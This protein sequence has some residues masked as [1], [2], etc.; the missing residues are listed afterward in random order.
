M[1]VK[2]LIAL[3]RKENPEAE[4]IFQDH[5]QEEGELNGEISYVAAVDSETLTERLGTDR[6][7]A[8]RN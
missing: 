7:V 8:L 5:D 6:I 1:K 2:R 4:V 3:L